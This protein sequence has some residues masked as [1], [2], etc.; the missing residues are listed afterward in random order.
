M[1]DLQTIKIVFLIVAPFFV[2]TMIAVIHASQRKF[3]TLR[4]KVVWMLVAAIPFIG[5]VVYFLIGRRKAPR[6]P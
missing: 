5:F 2:L 1:M 6:H 4:Q 3:A